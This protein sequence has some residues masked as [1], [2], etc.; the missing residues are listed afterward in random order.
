MPAPPAALLQVRGRGQPPPASASPPVPGLGVPLSPRSAGTAAAPSARPGSRPRPGPA[1][2]AR[3]FLP[4]PETGLPGGG[5]GAAAREPWSLWRTRSAARR[6]RRRRREPRA[7]D[8]RCERGGAGGRAPGPFPCAAA[9]RSPGSALPL[10]SGT[11]GRGGGRGGMGALAR[12]GAGDAPR[13][14]AHAPG[15]RRPRAPAG[16]RLGVPG[17]WSPAPPRAVCPE[18]ALGCS[19]F[20]PT[21]G[22]PVLLR[23]GVHPTPAPSPPE[24]GWA[25]HLQGT[26]G[27]LFISG[28]RP[29]SKAA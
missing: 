8:G 14:C 27:S 18:A 19:G 12:A 5:G 11:P 9:P 26:P 2:S 24:G 28:Y 25:P 15:P 23:L 10:F 20:V 16:T 29:R 3:H 1:P 17:A 21:G 6:R 13:R 22:F 4:G 7:G